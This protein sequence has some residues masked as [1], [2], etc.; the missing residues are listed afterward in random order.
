MPNSYS[1]YDL[2]RCGENGREKSVRKR[3]CG[4]ILSGILPAIYSF[5]VEVSGTRRSQVR[6]P[7]EEN[8]ET[9]MNIVKGATSSKWWEQ[10]NTKKVRPT[11][12]DLRSC[13][14]LEDPCWMI[15]GI[16]WLY[17]KIRSSRLCGLLKFQHFVR[18]VILK[19]MYED[20]RPME[21]VWD[22][23]NMF[24]SLGIW[25]NYTSKRILN[26]LQAITIVNFWDNY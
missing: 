14:S 16:F 5:T 24:E 8:I 1:I 2:L 6:N 21:S 19:S 10:N 15:W 26:E 4:Q 22:W 17:C 23:L 12:S 7:L 3:V 20:R 25:T 13:L 18:V 11:I 9:V